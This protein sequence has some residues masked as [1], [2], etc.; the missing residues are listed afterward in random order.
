[1]GTSPDVISVTWLLVVRTGDL[2]KQRRE[3]KR[4]D[5][6]AFCLDHEEAVGGPMC[7]LMDLCRWEPRS[8]QMKRPLFVT[9]PAL[10]KEIES[11]RAKSSGVVA[12]GR[13]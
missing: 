6:T 7:E 10:C 2:K 8:S 5:P 12:G 13:R 9:E 11:G 3:A 1:V 4:N